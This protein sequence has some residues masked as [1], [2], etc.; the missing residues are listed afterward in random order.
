[1][2]QAEM[3]FL[4][5]ATGTNKLTATYETVK[6]HIKQYVHKTCKH[7][8]DIAESLRD[9]EKMDLAAEMPM[10]RMS[11]LV[12]E[13]KERLRKIEQDGYNVLY[14]T[15]VPNYMDTK[16]T[17]DT[18]L[19]RAYALVLST[20]CNGTMQHLIEEHPDFESTIHNDPI[21]LLKA[22]KIVMHDPIRAKY[23]YTSL[24]EVLMRTLHIKQLEHESL[25]DY[26]KRLKQSRDV[27]KS[28]IGGDIL[29]KFIENLPGY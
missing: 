12:A 3:K 17:L 10:K 4:P 18:N 25:I 21:E 6:T 26:M 20:Y 27:L 13:S 22:I 7:R 16:I 8:Q 23:H 5:H 14:S 11:R 19:G 15:E 1:M 29:N 24:T 9:L 28:H 2:S